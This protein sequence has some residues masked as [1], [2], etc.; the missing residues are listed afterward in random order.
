MNGPV[1]PRYPLSINSFTQRS[2]THI[3]HCV[4]ELTNSIGDLC[5]GAH[6]ITCSVP[7]VFFTRSDCQSILFNMSYLKL[8][9]SCSLYSLV[10]AS[11]WVIYE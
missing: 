11:A 8:D 5:K 4:V 9:L 7:E 2:L 6:V 3:T 1:A 10:S